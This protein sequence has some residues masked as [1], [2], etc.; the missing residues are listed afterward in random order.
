MKFYKTKELGPKLVFPPIVFGGKLSFIPSFLSASTAATYI[1]TAPTYTTTII[2]LELCPLNAEFQHFIL[3]FNKVSLPLKG[4]I[5]GWKQRGQ[6]MKER[7]TLRITFSSCDFLF[8]EIWTSGRAVSIVSQ[9]QIGLH[10][11]QG[12]YIF[13]I[14][15]VHGIKLWHQYVTKEF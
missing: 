3:R 1:F 14:G 9:L 6:G 12:Y 11:L 15:F 4:G 8:F 10:S 2:T 13:G 5:R 7:M